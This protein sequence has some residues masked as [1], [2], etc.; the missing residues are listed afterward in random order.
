MERPVRPAE[1]LGPA[2]VLADTRARPAEPVA[3]WAA[4]VAS[5]AVADPAATQVPAGP[6]RYGPL[7]NQGS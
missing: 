3:D 2:R 4:S 1:P 5:S 7:A 6:S